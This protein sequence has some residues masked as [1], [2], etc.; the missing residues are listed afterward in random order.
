MKRL[1][2]ITSHPVQYNAPWFKLLASENKIVIKVFY[3]WGQSQAGIKYDPGFARDIEW[4]IPLLD[5][6]DY[7]F[8]KNISANPGTHH[9]KGIINPGL[10]SEIETWK[11]DFILIFGWSFHSHLKC[12]RHFHNKLPVLF[13]GDSTLLD[14]KKGIKKNIRRLF[15][16]WVYRHIDFA[17]YAG[18]ENKKYFKAHGLKEDQLFFAPHAIDNKRFSEPDDAYIAKASLWR[19]EIGIEEDDFVILFAGKFEEKKNPGFLFEL[20]E[21]IPE[22][23]IKFLLVGNGKLETVLKNKGNNN[24]R[25]I[26]LDFQNQQ[27]MPVVYRIGNIFILPSK[28]P[29]ETWGLAVNEAMACARPVIVSAKAG[30][31]SDLVKENQ[32]GII[33]EEHRFDKC[34][35]FISALFTD[36]L[37]EKNMGFYSEKIIKAYS[38]ESIVK[39]IYSI[40]QI[41]NEAK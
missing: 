1:A 23:R 31:A 26:Y 37:L 30:C 5:G 10:I 38:F 2:I 14:E 6:Y 27:K 15:L 8:V 41:K 17:L 33:F 12:L 36:K 13:R 32:N 3:T 22:H 9:F 7:T 11:A 20:A 19:K 29:G 16:K 40:L 21:R 34:I 18:E 24:K 39:T 25:F 4:D 28:G 35:G